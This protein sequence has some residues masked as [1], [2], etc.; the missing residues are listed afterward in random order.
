MESLERVWVE[1]ED[2]GKKMDDQGFKQFVGAMGG[3]TKIPLSEKDFITKLQRQMNL[4]TMMQQQKYTLKHQLKKKVTKNL[5]RERYDIPT[6][7]MVRKA[8]ADIR[9]SVKAS[10]TLNRIEALDRT[11][12]A[13]G[14]IFFGNELT[15]KQIQQ[16]VKRL[17]GEQVTKNKHQYLLTLRE[18]NQLL[19]GAPPHIGLMF[20]SDKAYDFKLLPG[21]IN[22]PY[23][24]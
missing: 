9:Q 5:Y 20:H 21:F 7:L 11:S 15:E 22:V 16:A 3:P 23:N 18:A 19:G 13:P 1:L 10:Q 17:H 4:T 6:D 12:I 14:L 2:E 8:D 24:F